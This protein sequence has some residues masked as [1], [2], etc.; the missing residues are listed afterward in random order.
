MT[1]NE[2]EKAIAVFDKYPSNL[3]P[4]VYALGL[5]GETGEVCDKMKKVIRDHNGEFDMRDEGILFELGD[6]LWYVTRIASYFGFSLQEV[7]DKNHGKL[8][9]RWE[10]GKIEGSDDDR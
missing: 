3:I 1:P 6:C 4:L 9:S 2:Y 5:A 8:K 7:I 10:R